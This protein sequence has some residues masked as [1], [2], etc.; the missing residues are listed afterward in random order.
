MEPNQ[1]VRVSLSRL[2]EEELQQ[3]LPRRSMDVRRE[4]M[5]RAA[6][7]RRS[8]RLL[9]RSRNSSDTVV[10]PSLIPERMANVDRAAIDTVHEPDGVESSGS[11]IQ[12]SVIEQMANVNQDAIETAHEPNGIE[13]SGS[14]IQPSVVEQMANVDHEAVDAT[15]EL[16]GL[17]S[18]GSVI[19]CYYTPGAKINTMLLW[20]ENDKQLYKRNKRNAA[21]HLGFT[22]IINGCVCRIFEKS[23]NEIKTYY[24]GPGYNGHKHGTA[25]KV[26]EANILKTKIKKACENLG[27]ADSGTN[28]KSVTQ[29]FNST[30]ANHG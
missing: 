10:G 19:Q 24:F 13:S 26:K 30:V 14:V 18:S 5:A 8:A 7:T 25:E 17:E 6:E 11:I 21:G 2:T 4:L 20:C 22:C 12:S 3:H 1:E 16:N 29:I 27:D 15:H 9:A 23:I 28:I